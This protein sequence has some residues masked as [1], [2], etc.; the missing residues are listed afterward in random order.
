M[1]TKS[2]VSMETHLC[3][4]CGTEYETEAILLDR[5]VRDILEPKTCTGWGMCPEHEA[6]KGDGYIALVE[7]K[8]PPDGETLAPGDAD[9]TGRICHVR[10]SVWGQIFDVPPPPKSMC[11]V[12]PGVIERLETIP[13]EKV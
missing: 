1:T 5:R 12:E 6:M 4:V 8:V 7:A 9:R 13:T 3:V 10:E 11:F 2:H